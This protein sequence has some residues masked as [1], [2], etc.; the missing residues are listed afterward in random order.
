V[1]SDCLPLERTSGRKQVQIRQSAQHSDGALVLF[2]HCGVTLGM[3]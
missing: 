3:S 2:R 1:V